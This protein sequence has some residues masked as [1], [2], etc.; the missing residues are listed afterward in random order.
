MAYVGADFA[1]VEREFEAL[2]GYN[3]I[4]RMAQG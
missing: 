1:A 2:I 3:E 4:M